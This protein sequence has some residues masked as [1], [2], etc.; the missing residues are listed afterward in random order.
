MI[1]WGCV[2][3]LVALMGCIPAFVDSDL[4]TTEHSAALQVRLLLVGEP[5]PAGA[6]FLGDVDGLSCRHL[7]TEPPA[8]VAVALP[9]LQVHAYRLGANAVANV[10]CTGSGIS[11]FGINCWNAVYCGGTAIKTLGTP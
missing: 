2:L 7:A 3:V 9:Q 1:R 5:V 4:A 11:A 8:T 10:S 6:Q